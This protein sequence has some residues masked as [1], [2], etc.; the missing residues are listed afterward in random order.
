MLRVLLVMFVNAVVGGGMEIYMKKKTL[1]L[2]TLILIMI[3]AM[4]GCEGEETAPIAD[5]NPESQSEYSGGTPWAA[6]VIKDNLDSQVDI[7]DDY[8]MAVNSSWIMDNEILPGYQTEQYMDLASKDIDERIRE[9]LSDEY[10]DNHDAE[11]VQTYYNAFLNWDDRNATGT[12]PLTVYLDS[13]ENISS[14]EDIAGLYTDSQYDIAVLFPMIDWTS[15]QDVSRRALYL[16]APD[17]FLDDPSDYDYLDG[18]D[19]YVSSIYDLNKNLVVTVLLKCGYSESEAEE[20]FDG[21][22]EFEG[23]FAKYCYSYNDLSSVEYTELKNSQVYSNEEIKAFGNFSMI[24]RITESLGYPEDRQYV[25]YEKIDYFENFDSFVNDNNIE[26]IKDYLIAHA[27]ADSSMFL[28]RECFEA[29]IDMKN[30]IK[31][32]FTI[33]LTLVLLVGIAAEDVTE[34]ATEIVTEP[35][36]GSPVSELFLHFSPVPPPSI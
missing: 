28:D 7:K 3:C 34:P 32:L 1:L 6:S 15:S 36:T 22:I 29:Y 2:I 5:S 23:Q 8:Y 9:I 11:L 35:V 10:Q 30:E 25:L 13:I 27:A 17:M 18:S 26:L 14:T 24:N 19:E 16:E 33:L 31:K 12:E 20:I 21:A 4:S